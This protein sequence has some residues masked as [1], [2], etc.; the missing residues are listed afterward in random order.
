MKKKLA[1]VSS[2]I[3]VLNLIISLFVGGIEALAAESMGSHV[4]NFTIG[5]GANSPFGLN[6]QSAARY[7]ISGSFEKPLNAASSTGAG[8]N[9]EELR[10]DM[11]EP[12]SGRW[13][14]GFTD[15]AVNK[16]TERGLNVLGL[17]SYNVDRSGGGR[18]QP[19]YSMPDIN[20]WRTYVATVVNRYKDRVRY[21]EI[22]NEP[23]DTKYFNIADFNQRAQNY[24]QL[25]QVSYDTIKG[26]DGGLQVVT[27][28]ISGFDVPFLEE[29]IAR[30]G[31]GKFDIL[32][33]HPYVNFPAS[34]ESKY[35]SD[36]QLAYFEAFAARV[37]KPVWATEFGWDTRGPTSVDENRQANYIA[38]ASVEGLASALQKMFIY[39]FRD[40]GVNLQDGYGI[41]R[42][43]WVTPKPAYVVYKNLITRLN[44]ATF[45]ERFETFDA[46]KVAIDSFNGANNF[47]SYANAPSTINTYLSGDQAHS[48]AT[49]L[50]IDYAFNGDASNYI[51][52]GRQVPIDGQPTKVGFWI[53]G[54]NKGA[55]VRVL[56]R[57]ANNTLFYYD[58]GSAG[59]TGWQRREAWLSGETAPN[60][61]PSSQIRY[62]IKFDSIQLI[63]RPNGA[64]W[65]GS[66]YIDDVYAAGG[67]R[68]YGYRFERN[69]KNIDVMWV[70]NGS[71]TVTLPTNDAVGTLYDRSGNSSLIAANDGNLTVNI[72]DDMV[73]LE[74]SGKALP[75]S[76][77]GTNPSPVQCGA[78]PTTVSPNT[79]FPNDW[80]QNFW[81]R[82]DFY[83]VGA[84]SYVWGDKPFAS[85]SEYYYQALDGNTQNTKQRQV[86]YF[87]K[88]RMEITRASSNP[89]AT[90]Y[91][92][93]GLLTVELITG[94][95]QLGD[96]LDDPLQFSQCQ[97]ANV[98]VAGDQDDTLG[99]K[100]ASLNGRR[101]DAAKAV[102]TAVTETIDSSGN[103]GQGDSRGVV[104]GYYEPL[105]KH[106]IAKP[107]WDF[108]NDPTQRIWV[109]GS[110]VIGKL[111]NPYYEAPGLP[112]TEAYWAKVKVA[113]QV[114]DVLVQA[115]E[116]RVLT[117]TPTNPAAFKVEWGNIGRHY[118]FWRYGI[119]Y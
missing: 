93:N 33:V 44:G 94:K 10:W 84:R 72:N 18:A 80:F 108:L 31:S 35:W 2:L 59:G 79:A 107:F 54:D 1:V 71:G 13:D 20:A 25:L 114:K 97:P 118:F 3:V 12:Y 95:M 68:G 119:S 51:Q 65:S 112:I 49:S 96:I 40:D 105:T 8:W 32:G 85:G 39:Q 60:T 110:P 19:N 77:T 41:V 101:A 6:V 16:S 87:D 63:S 47:S 74:H 81:K 75:G 73:F 117:Y 52:V 37:G 92:T 76:S 100:Y 66:V 48:G 9:R 103:L 43:D 55:D 24:A 116:R 78:R 38:R 36:T 62:P 88:S 99:P 82:Y 27:G 64:K 15:E 46:G 91:V 5:Q 109:N 69:G 111:F 17:L 50:R 26:I 102:G 90:G 86:V 104:G 28:G 115:F 21:W 30:G 83:A 42:N 113:G 56:I 22:W 61:P 23:S 34:P 29:V 11:V 45:K 70:D 106:T 53:Y 67:A 4:P 89:L 57:D 58:V 7:G 98:P 14:W